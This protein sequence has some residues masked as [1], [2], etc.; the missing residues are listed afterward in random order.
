[1]SKQEEIQKLFYSNP[2]LSSTE[3]ALQV[4]CSKRT[5]RYALEKIRGKQ[6]VNPAKILLFDLET[7]PM[8]VYS[9][10]LWKQLIQPHQVMKDWSVISWSAKWLF[11]SNMMGMAVSPDDARD[12]KDSKIMKKLW[13]LMD[14][15]DIIIA[16]NANK[17]D[18]KRMNS[19]FIQN[20]MFR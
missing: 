18:V 19:R 9:W 12:R 3:L 2:S 1:M 5:V 8:E 10:G 13:D 6:G 20:G 16:H 4:G 14:E 15:A 17:F 11:D 7:S